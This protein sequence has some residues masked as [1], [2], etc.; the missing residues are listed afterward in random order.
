[1]RPLPVPSLRDLRPLTHGGLD[2]GALASLGIS[3]ESVLDFSV[4][5]NPL[6]PHP[7]VLKAA[8]SGDLTLYP[9]R[10]CGALKSRLAR[11]HGVKES[12]ILVTNGASQAIWLV[13]AAYLGHGRSAAVAAP[14]YGGYEASSSALGAEV[15]LWDCGKAMLEDGFMDVLLW[16]HLSSDPPAVL[17]LCS[18]NNPTGYAMSRKQIEAILE[19][20]DGGPT[21]VAVD[22]AYD[23][24]MEDPPGLE[25]LI[26]SNRLILIRSMT[27]DYGMPGVRIGYAIGSE[28]AV[29]A[30]ALV[31]PDWSVSTQSQVTAMA[32]LDHRA[33]YQEQW[34]LLREE[35]KRL[36]LALT[37]LGIDVTKGE[38]NF[39]L[40]RHGACDQLIAY[41]K[42]SRILVRDC[43]SFGLRG[44]FRIGVKGRKADDVLLKAV[45][46]F[47]GGEV[48]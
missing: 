12:Q 9:D 13:A 1:M 31:Q 29:S 39:L 33:Y 14:A 10:F 25:G 3:P 20:C 34:R 43:R 4:S 5:V 16:D 18:P 6:P 15:T 30:M 35:K 7:E 44:F 37:G 41:L 42:D 27:K 24:F 36:S 46:A 17:W 23:C 45:Q 40:C 22:Q 19:R 21:M 47:L 11:A 28:E 32:F 8:T 26:S 48:P 2:Y 38:G